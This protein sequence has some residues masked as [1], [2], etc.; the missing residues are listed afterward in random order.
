MAQPSRITLLKTWLGI[1]LAHGMLESEA[2]GLYD[3]MDKLAKKTPV[4]TVTDL[5][6]K[7][8]NNLITKAKE[9]LSNDIIIADVTIFVAAGDNPQYRDV[10]TVLRQVIQGLNRFQEQANKYLWDEEFQEELD[11]NNLDEED[12]KPFF[13]KA[14]G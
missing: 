12:A 3:E 7:A 6:L 13:T 4:E 8:I 9:L 1:K 11:D 10:V 14:R 2:K 5:Q